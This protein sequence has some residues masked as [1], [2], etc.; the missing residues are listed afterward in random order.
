[1]PPRG[2]KHLIISRRPHVARVLYIIEG[3]RSSRPNVN[4]HFAAYS[5]YMRP[6]MTLTAYRESCTH[7][8][9]NSY[10]FSTSGRREVSSIRFQKIG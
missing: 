5:T 4:K 9:I 6:G 7:S 8:V 2:R 3:L 10:A 1:M